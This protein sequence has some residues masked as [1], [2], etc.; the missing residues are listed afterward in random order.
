MANTLQQ[1]K[2]ANK[3]AMIPAGLKRLADRESLVSWSSHTAPIIERH[4]QHH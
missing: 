4:F 1:Q 2:Y 3:L